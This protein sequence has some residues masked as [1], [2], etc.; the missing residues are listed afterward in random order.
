MSF[1]RTHTL[2]NSMKVQV[3]RPQGPYEQFS[4]TF[5]FSI[6]FPPRPYQV[7]YFIPISPHTSCHYEALYHGK[8]AETHLRGGDFNDVRAIEMMLHYYIFRDILQFLKRFWLEN[9]LDVEKGTQITNA[10]SI[11]HFLYRKTWSTV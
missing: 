7:F 5:S 8:G 3:I 2:D 9:K 6:S 1:F 4:H 11:D 10:L